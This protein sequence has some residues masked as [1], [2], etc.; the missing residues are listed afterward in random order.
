[1]LIP[2]AAANEQRF[3]HLVAQPNDAE[4]ILRNTVRVPLMVPGTS[5]IFGSLARSCL[6][7]ESINSA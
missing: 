3:P 4:T 5:A 6:G 7:A 2:S 1:L